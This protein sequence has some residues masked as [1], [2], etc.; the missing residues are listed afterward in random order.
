M[1]VTI[2]LY[3]TMNTQISP[4]LSLIRGQFCSTLRRRAIWNVIG[5]VLTTSTLGLEE[6]ELQNCDLNLP[7]QSYSLSLRILLLSPS[8]IQA[9]DKE[10]TSSRLINFYHSRN[11][12]YYQNYAIAFFLSEDSFNRASGKCDLAG[13]LALQALVVECLPALIPIIP[14]PDSSCFFSCL[15]EYTTSLADIHLQTPSLTD[16]MALLSHV[17]S[18]H[19]NVLSDQERNILS[20]LFPSL[21]SL[22]QAVRSREG[23][24]VLVDYLGEVRTR[25]IADFWD[26]DRVCE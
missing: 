22:S 18:A 17:T 26:H 3:T 19:P 16:S 20:D 8:S 21:R 4:S 10:N 15:E 12:T 23:W 25:E 11:D 1:C 9:S 13:L 6:S 24:N 7:L 5:P 2:Q 14:I